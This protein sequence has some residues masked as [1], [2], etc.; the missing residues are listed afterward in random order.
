MQAVNMGIEA[1]VNDCGP[2][3]LGTAMLALQALNHPTCNALLYFIHIVNHHFQVAAITQEY[4]EAAVQA[5]LMFA[6]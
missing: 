5:V 6:L 1:S 3:S 2:I 4:V